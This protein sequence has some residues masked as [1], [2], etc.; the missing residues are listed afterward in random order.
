METGSPEIRRL[1]SSRAESMR[2]PPVNLKSFWFIASL[3][4]WI[5]LSQSNRQQRGEEK[6][7]SCFQMSPCACLSIF[8]LSWRLCQCPGSVLHHGGQRGALLRRLAQ[9]YLLLDGTSWVVDERVDQTGHCE[10]QR[11]GQRRGQSVR[12]DLLHSA[13]THEVT[14]RG[15]DL[16]IHRR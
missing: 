7:N 3:S 16:W 11:R 6:T 10:S 12:L 5:S 13:A 14:Q 1:Q 15:T 4:L 8:S 9:L 2:R